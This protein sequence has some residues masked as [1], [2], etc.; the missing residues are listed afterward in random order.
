MKLYATAGPVSGRGSEYLPVYVEYGS[1]D[2]FLYG[3][4]DLV[5]ALGYLL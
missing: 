1:V 3:F 5:E 2:A 4:F